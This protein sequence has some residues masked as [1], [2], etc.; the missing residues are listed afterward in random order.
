MKEVNREGTNNYEIDKFNIY[1]L[2]DVKT[3]G[4]QIAAISDNEIEFT[5]GN[6]YT[7][8][9]NCIFINDSMKIAESIESCRF[10]TGMEN[11]KQIVYVT[12]KSKSGAERTIEYI[13]NDET[14]DLAYFNN[15][16]NY[17]H[18]MLLYNETPKNSDGTLTANATYI[19]EGNVAV[20]PKG[21]KVSDVA[22]EQSIENGLV[23]QDEEGNEFVWI[24]VNYEVQ[25][26]EEKNASG[27]YSSFLKI[28]YRSS[29]NTDNDIGGKRGLD[30]TNDSSYTEPYK[31]GYKEE[32]IEY[33]AMIKSVQENKGFYIGRY[34]AGTEMA[35]T[36]SSAGEGKMVINTIL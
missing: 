22:E 23:I 10:S 34:E 32:N 9:N 24:P 5:L 4:N 1:F 36:N 26:G 18:G 17:T 27:L 28:F 31:S 19:E 12:I 2:K 14:N 13:L 7:F 6:K 15:E 29:W 21:F 33:N 35:R 8:N 20:I 16:T 25:K 3:Q 11:G 30:L